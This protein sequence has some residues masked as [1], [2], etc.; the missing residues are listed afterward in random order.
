MPLLTSA[1]NQLNPRISNK[2]E[3]DVER[4]IAADVVELVTEW[5]HAVCPPIVL[6]ESRADDL[7]VRIRD[8][9]AVFDHFFQ[10]S[11][12]IWRILRS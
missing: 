12:A 7:I 1:P 2:I 10:A 6:N 9:V 11:E 5:S 4:D 8:A 3:T